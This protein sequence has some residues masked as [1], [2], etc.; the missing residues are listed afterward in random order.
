MM[1]QESVGSKIKARGGFLQVVEKLGK[2]H[3]HLILESGL[4]L[5]LEADIL[6]DRTIQTGH[7]KHEVQSHK[8]Q[9]MMG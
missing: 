8:L 9:R 2:R 4:R 3:W 6:A 1:S 7:L 5:H